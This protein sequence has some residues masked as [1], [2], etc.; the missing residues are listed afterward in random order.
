MELSA[1]FGYTTRRPGLLYT[2]DCK[3]AALATRAEIAAH[4]DFSLMPLP[5]TGETATHVES[6]ITAIVEGVQ[7]A[8]LL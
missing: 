6:W 4:H 2:G 1:E 5:R 8:T 3:R 7:E